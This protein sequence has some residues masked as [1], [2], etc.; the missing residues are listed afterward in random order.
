MYDV[1]SLR[2]LSDIFD[3][4][5]RKQTLLFRLLY[6]VEENERSI[7]MTSN[8]IETTKFSKDFNET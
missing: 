2:L 8:K 6:M 1:N 3:W 5:I 4:T 7:I